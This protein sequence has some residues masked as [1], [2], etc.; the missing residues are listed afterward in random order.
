MV[1]IELVESKKVVGLLCIFG[2]NAELL[3]LLFVLPGRVVV[4]GE[5]SVLALPNS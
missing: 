1:V 3:L 2:L 5:S 4:S